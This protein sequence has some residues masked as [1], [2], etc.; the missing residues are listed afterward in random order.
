LLALLV[1]V[2]HAPFSSFHWQKTHRVLNLPFNTSSSQQQRQCVC[3]K[4]KSKQNII[5]YRIGFTL[6]I[7]LRLTS[8]SCRP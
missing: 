4:K 1:L 3:K 5:H 2:V 6:I 8:N 7:S